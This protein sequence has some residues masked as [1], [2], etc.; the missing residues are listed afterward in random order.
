MPAFTAVGAAVVSY[1]GG[2][3]VLGS[4]GAIAVGA[5]VSTGA[6]YITSRVINGNPNKGNNSAAGS[7]G[8]RIQV[9]PATN[10]K[11]PVL[12]GSAYVNGMITDARLKSIGGT[13]NDTMYY[14]IV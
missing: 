5:I 11:I 4:F 13:T 8:G 2:A 12:Y 6:A 9:A 14:C 10:N 3:A 1:L 7:Q